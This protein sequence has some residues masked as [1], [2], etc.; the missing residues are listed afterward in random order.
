MRGANDPLGVRNG[1]S[2]LRGII[3]IGSNTIRLVVYGGPS[4]VPFVILNEKIVAQLGRQVSI[5]GMLGEEAMDIAYG[6]VARF[7]ELVRDLEVAQVDVV[8]TAAIRDAGNGSELLERIRSLGLSPRVLSG[9]EEA[10]V[11]AYGVMGAFPNARGIVADLGG[12]SLELVE[13]DGPAIGRAVSLPLGTLRLAELRE[14]DPDGFRKGISRRLKEV[15]WA[16]QDVRCLY[17]VGGTFRAMA[18]LAMEQAGSVL[19]DPHGVSAGRQGTAALLSRL[20]KEDPASL[21]ESPR[22]PAMRAA[23][24]PDAAV[25]LQALI[26]KFD[27]GRIVF[28]SWGLREGLL[29]ENLGPVE[30]AQD[31]LLVG[32]ANFGTTQGVSPTLAARVAGWTSIA[33]QQGG[34]GSERLRLAATTLALSAMQVEPNLRLRAASDWALHKRWIAIEPHE[35]GMLAAAIAGNSNECDLDPGL[36]TLADDTQLEEA[37]CWGLA[38]RLCRRLGAGSRRSLQASNLTIEHGVLT[39]RLE[40]RSRALFGTPNEKD[41]RLLGT[42]LGLDYSMKIVP[43]GASCAEPEPVSLTAG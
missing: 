23:K 10:R 22:I 43:D 20:A 15:G 24:L 7:A 30:R 31:P 36:S 16:A 38:I 25:L 18:V 39:L 3:D 35:R 26:K 19:S 5:D 1:A 37:L 34:A 21:A 42:R 27:P 9:P 2:R 4:R 33:A 41:L 13:I 11:S 17:L 6:A 32:V 40:D 28:S 14:R 29:Y 12:G 8:A